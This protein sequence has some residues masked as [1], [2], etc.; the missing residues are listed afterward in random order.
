MQFGFYYLVLLLFVVLLKSAHDNIRHTN[1][2]SDFF[3]WIVL[4]KIVG[5]ILYTVAVLPTCFAA[6]IAFYEFVLCFAYLSKILKDQ[7]DTIFDLLSRNVKSRK[8]LQRRILRVA[9]HFNVVI[10]HFYAFNRHFNRALNFMAINLLF[11]IIYP[12]LLIFA[13]NLEPILVAI[14]L[15]FYLTVL[16]FVLLIVFVNFNFSNG[17][18]F[19][20]FSYC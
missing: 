7:T 2:E 14:Y 5:Y 20:K 8:S 12:T 18:S 6:Y 10:T 19:S 1:P 3:C 17:V 4:I 13:S 16:S 11:L 9:V 15:A